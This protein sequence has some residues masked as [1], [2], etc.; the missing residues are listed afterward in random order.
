MN[1]F[2]FNLRDAK[3]VTKSLRPKMLKNRFINTK[4]TLA[5]KPKEKNI[6]KRLFKSIKTK[7]TGDKWSNDDKFV[8]NFSIR[9][10]NGVGSTAAVPRHQIAKKEMTTNGLTK[11]DKN[12][13]NKIYM[14]KGGPLK[15]GDAMFGNAGMKNLFKSK[16]LSKDNKAMLGRLAIAHEGSE[17]AVK[18]K[19][20]G[21]FFTH[22][23]PKVLIEESNMISTMPK[24][25]NA[26]KNILKKLRGS[27]G[28][29]DALNSLN[30]KY[31]EGRIN[32]R[33]KR[34]LV[35]KYKKSQSDIV[36]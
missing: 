8:S 21:R 15:D 24:K 27:T 9:K 31:G 17:L 30:F 26:S 34:H 36:S 22:L 3:S 6:F 23:S 35:E 14:P 29:T 4:Y 1:K 7:V 25:Y 33:M 19:E 32:R 18:P 28:E 2:A 20:V 12:M 11:Y 5:E 10:S 16:N 13:T